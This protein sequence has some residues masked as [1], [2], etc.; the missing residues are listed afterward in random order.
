MLLIMFSDFEDVDSRG[1][2]IDPLERKLTA[3]TD[4]NEEEYGDEEGRISNHNEESVTITPTPGFVIKTK[5]KSGEKVFINVCEH[6]NIPAVSTAIG[7]L[8]TNT[9]WPSMLSSSAR[10]FQ[11]EEDKKG[12]SDNA[13]IFDVAVNPSVLELSNRDESLAT[14]DLVQYL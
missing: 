3:V 1:T 9:K 14:R 13:T 11:D 10:S 4:S 7:T 2:D 6:N 8:K 5:K 12:R